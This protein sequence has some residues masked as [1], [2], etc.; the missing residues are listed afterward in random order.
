MAMTAAEMVMAMEVEAMVKAE[1][2]RSARRQNT[3]RSHWARWRSRRPERSSSM[4]TGHTPHRRWGPT[5]S[6]RAG[7]GA[8]EEVQTVAAVKWG[9]R[10]SA[11][12]DP[13]PCQRWHCSRI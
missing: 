3:H 12:T 7:T 13:S 9:A 8:V 5:R 4:H 10:P 6:R 2:W 11:E 1:L